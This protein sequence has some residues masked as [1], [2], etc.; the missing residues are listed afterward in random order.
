MIGYAESVLTIMN[1]ITEYN[2][3]W[4]TMEQQKTEIMTCDQGCMK[5]FLG[6][7]ANAEKLTDIWWKV[8]GRQESNYLQICS[9]TQFP[10][11]GRSFTKWRQT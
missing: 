9:L 10:I 8:H 3:Y 2:I 11:S 4:E 5:T 1:S 7:F 6:L